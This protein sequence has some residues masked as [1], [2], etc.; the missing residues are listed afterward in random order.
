[1]PARQ[2]PGTLFPIELD[3]R[4]ETNAERRSICAVAKVAR[5]FRSQVDVE[6]SRQ[7]QTQISFKGRSRIWQ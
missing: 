3:R 7:A 1:M 2:E 6:K 5:R 4:S